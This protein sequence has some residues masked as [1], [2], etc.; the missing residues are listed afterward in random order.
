[1][2]IDEKNGLIYV[3]LLVTTLNNIFQS[4]YRSINF[5][6]HIDE[7]TLTAI[8]RNINKSAFNSIGYNIQAVFLYCALVKKA[9]VILVINVMNGIIQSMYRYIFFNMELAIDYGNCM[10]WRN[11]KYQYVN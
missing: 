5:N 9:V 8:L 6:V 1:M 7:K 10:Y 3:V 4:K 2:C 11:I